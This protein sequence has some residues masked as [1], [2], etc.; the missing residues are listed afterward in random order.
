VSWVQD[1]LASLLPDREDTALLEACLAAGER[2]H[3]G[4]ARYT[5]PDAHR[6]APLDQRLAAAR[7]LLP[8]LAESASRNH[9]SVPAGGRAVL[10]AAVFREELRTTRFR[11]IAAEAL[12]VLTGEAVPVLVTR[13]TALAASV[14]PRW[15]LRHCHDLDLL[16]PE[17]ALTLA[18]RSL[19]A[20]GWRPSLPRDVA[21]SARLRHPSGMEAAL[22]TAPFPVRF[23]GATVEEF[24]R[25]A[26]EIVVEGV[27]VR[28]PA[29]E[30]TL[31]HI[32]GHAS[33]DA[34]GRRLSWATDAW[35]LLSACMDL[36]WR[37]ILERLTAYRLALPA[38][39]FLRYLSDL[40]ARL[41]RAVLMDLTQT[42][43]RVPR[44]D[45]D[46]AIAGVVRAT[47]GDLGR[48]WRAQPS[49]QGRLALARWAVAPSAG[50]VRRAF[51]PAADWLLPLCY[52]YRPARFVTAALGR[53]MSSDSSVSPSGLRPTEA[54]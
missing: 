29:P 34:R 50:Y 13:G 52:L 35:Y 44:A 38:A 43:D 4:W 39:V 19:V 18:V 3:A 45:V 48:L 16:L 26:S 6:G 36:R 32:L 20:A 47:S 31:V 54:G 51:T 41:P 2:A 22:H 1:I 12:A 15:S 11:R 33:C 8:C 24:S 37:L 27:P 42:A 21:G 46:C 25:D 5:L 28:M 23:Y 14:Y 40:G 30:L 49:W 53:R 7:R 10:N 17:R 9:L